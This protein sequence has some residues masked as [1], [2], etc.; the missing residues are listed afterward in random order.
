M[1]FKN[2]KLFANELDQND[3]LKS[4]RDQFYYPKD[5]NEEEVLYLCGNSLGLQPKSV[6]SF[7]EMELNAWE[8]DGVLG[9][10]GRW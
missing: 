6:R 2:S 3:P 5:K 10:H 9:Q 1:I 7:V 4:F 8:K